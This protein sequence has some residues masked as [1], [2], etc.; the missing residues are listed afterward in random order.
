[1]GER[2]GQY[3]L[4]ARIGSGGMADVFLARRFGVE[5]FSRICAVKRM[6]AGLLNDEECVRMFLDE[7]RYGAALNHPNIAQV[8]DL[9]RLGETYFIAMEFVDGPDLRGLLQRSTRDG[10]AI[11]VDAAV[12]VAARVAEG[13]HHVHEQ[14]DPITGEPLNLVHRDI[15]HSNI[16]V[17]RHGDVKITDFGILKTSAPRAVTRVGT[18]KGTIGYL[19]PEQCLELPIDRRADLFNLGI[20]LYELLTRTRVFLGA[21]D[22][23]TLKRVAYADPAPPSKLDARVDARLDQIIL[24]CLQKAPDR[25]P[26]TALEVM[27]ALD[28]WL[29]DQGHRSPRGALVSW[30]KEHA[31]DLYPSA[32]ARAERRLPT[33]SGGVGRRTTGEHDPPE[34]GPGDTAFVDLEELDAPTA[35]KLPQVSGV[36]AAPRGHNLPR[37]ADPVIGREALTEDIVQRCMEGERLLTLVGIAGIGKSRLALAAARELRAHFREAGGIWYAS[38]GEIEDLQTACSVIAGSLG[39]CL[40]GGGTA[41][42]SIGEIGAA[43]A[44]RGAVMLVL[45]DFDRLVGQATALLGSWLE[46]APDLRVLVTSRRVLRVQ[47]E[48]AMEVGPLALPVE[49]GDP[50]RSA[51]VRLFVERASVARPGYRPAGAELHAVANVVTKLEGI[52]LAI[53]LAASRLRVLGAKH[54]LE[55][56]EQRFDVLTDAGGT[57]RQRTLRAA[58]DWS[59]DMLERPERVALAHCTVFRG[60]FSMDAAEAVIDLSGL[61]TP[62]LV[63][64]V[65]Q[66]LRDRSML[67]AWE[68]EAAPGEVRLAMYESI[69][70]YALDKEPTGALDAALDRHLKWCVEVGR[71]LAERVFTHEGIA[72]RAGLAAE[73]DNLLAAHERA[74]SA[75]PRENWRTEAALQL[76]IPLS[77]LLGERG[78]MAM[79]LPLLERA[80]ALAD[81]AEEPADLEGPMAA[82]LAERADVLSRLGRSEEGLPDA[83]RAAALAERAGDR[84]LV[85]LAWLR[86]GVCQRFL[87]EAQASMQAAEEAGRIAEEAGEAWVAARARNLAGA[88][89]YERG[90]RLPALRCFE[91][92]LAA[93]QQ[94][95]DNE[96]AARCEGN[97]GCVYADYGR[98][99][100]AEPWFIKAYEHM[101]A[102][103]NR[104]GQA[105]CLCY[106]GLVAQER[107]DL[108]RARRQLTQSAV[109]MGEVGARHRQV[110]VE[111][112]LG[113]CLLAAGE[114][115][116]ARELLEPAAGFFTSVGDRRTA[117]MFLAS[118]ALVHEL[119]GRP[120]DAR[121]DTAEAE[122]LAA[123]QGDPIA[124]CVVDLLRG[125]IEARTAA[126]EPEPLRS[127]LRSMARGRARRAMLRRPATEAHPKGQPALGAISSEVRFALGQLERCLPAAADDR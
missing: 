85:A 51:A 19:S 57:G 88:S 47:G 120:A 26:G 7:A 59:W 4:I 117:S 80:L 100:R 28:N 38:L 42:R 66:S 93:A 119:E 107:G 36:G 62:A 40:T 55:R 30:L 21:N 2:F 72:A 69:R 1:M 46:G 5:G 12:W 126:Q 76:C 75:L 32:R 112:L 86:Q 25:R 11:P 9:G 8:L 71:Y 39:I 105:V 53:E 106:L 33:G 125:A 6:R 127:Q 67:R 52:P 89:H 49:G 121:R 16:L 95:G 110:H 83:V 10:V 34:Q 97:I 45:D 90:E 102:L 91:A 61:D 73:L 74:C 79:L 114:L 78:P 60:G 48:R 13:L 50:G 17:S 65:V 29:I 123:A 41:Q 27:T 82:V 63:L 118:L 3:E 122:R 113:W 101:Q 44:G 77:R 18:L 64:D 31:A 104:R 23:E 43:L 22:F 116:R 15:G 94:A 20:V 108:G 99:D 109:M 68:H 96:L 84:G 24:G 111:G 70:A 124:I 81:G 35:P 103:D 92:A 54:L 115:P 58:I 56:L 14:C 87:G 98:I 37:S